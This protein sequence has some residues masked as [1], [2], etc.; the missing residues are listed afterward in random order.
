MKNVQVAIQDSR[1]ANSIRT[2]LL[3][4]GSHKVQ[5][6]PMPDLRVNGIIVVDAVDL[7]SFPL[8][9]NEQDRLVVIVHKERDDLSKIWRAGVRY[10]VFEGDSPHRARNVVLGAELSLWS[11]R[12][13]GAATG[14][15]QRPQHS[16]TTLSLWPRQAVDMR[17][18]D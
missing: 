5:L 11:L 18:A 9:V 6:V 7:R 14:P 1:Y 15:P 2:L 13:R 16:N 10:V 17:S 8:L 12:E 4:D 3:Q